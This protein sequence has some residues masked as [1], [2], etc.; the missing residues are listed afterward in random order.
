[1][2]FIST[3]NGGLMVTKKDRRYTEILFQKLFFNNNKKIEQDE[4][5]NKL[6]EKL[7]WMSLFQILIAVCILLSVASLF[8]EIW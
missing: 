4:E 8:L 5:T 1:M 2:N 3:N 7:S 6:L